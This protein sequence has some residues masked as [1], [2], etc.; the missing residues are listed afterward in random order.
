MSDDMSGMGIALV[1]L[2]RA[3]SQLSVTAYFDEHL[4]GRE[5]QLVFQHGPRSLAHE[6]SVP[7]PGDYFALPQEAEG[8]V[9]L[10]RPDGG[11]EL[12]SNVCRHRQ[13]A[14]LRGR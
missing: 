13:A 9:L 5:Q 11:L 8:R 10:R 14:V 4:C 3:R 6:L 1:G 7:E 2:E 12:L